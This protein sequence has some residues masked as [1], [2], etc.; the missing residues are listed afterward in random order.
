MIQSLDAGQTAPL[1]SKETARI[2]AEWFRSGRST[3]AVPWLKA[4]SRW[5]AVAAE[6]ILDQRQLRPDPNYLEAPAA[7]GRASEVPRPQGAA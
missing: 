7:H 1:T 2:L 4:E 3:E 5:H 6:L